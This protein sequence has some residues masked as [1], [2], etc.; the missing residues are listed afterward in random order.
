MNILH[1]FFSNTIVAFTILIGIVV[2]AHELGHFLA[3][4]F[5]GIRVEEFSIG[6]GPKAFG[7]RKNQTE[8]RINWLPLGGYV[9]FFGADS[10]Q[11]INPEDK[12][13]SL[14]HAALYKRAIVSF[15]GPFANFVL[16]F[17]VMCLVQM[18]GLSDQ[19]PVVGVLPHS[20]AEKSGFETG[21][22][23]L[24]IDGKPVAGWSDLVK[25]IRV[26][27]NKTLSIS[28]QK[29]NQ[30]KVIQITPAAEKQRP[31]MALMSGRVALASH[32]FSASRK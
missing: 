13:Q 20:I 8:Y 15:A 26:S 25:I 2:F 32:P 10:S 6:F 16:S 1:A 31:S 14:L 9:R 24:S 29:E 22:R 23:I 28:L 3:G 21:D 5:F 7:F 17:L 11:E 19:P 12:K 27:A 4:K 18:H 30:I